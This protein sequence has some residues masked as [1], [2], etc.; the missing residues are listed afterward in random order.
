MRHSR[1]R[2]PFEGFVVIYIAIHVAL[3]DLSAMAVAGVLAITYVGHHQKLL[4]LLFDGTQGAL[5]NAI[6]GVR[7]RSGLVLRL[8]E[9]EQNNTA[10]TQ[11]LC[12]RALAHRFV[13]G[14][15]RMARHGADLAPHALSRADK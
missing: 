11:R 9:A 2:Q 13:H 1:G 5:Y 6:V 7:T 3:G 15:L 8:G 12:L 14:H 10:D 4:R